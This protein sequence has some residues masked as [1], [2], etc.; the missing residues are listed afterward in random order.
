MTAETV[1]GFPTPKAEAAATATTAKAPRSQSSGW[2]VKV[3]VVI[4]A[5]AWTIPT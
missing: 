4:I 5:L 3:L 2:L 1:E